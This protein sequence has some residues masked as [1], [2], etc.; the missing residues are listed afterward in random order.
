M[1]LLGIWF[2]PSGRINRR[3][4]WLRGIVLPMAINLFILGALAILTISHI[5][6]ISH[7]LFNREDIGDLDADAVE[8]MVSATALILGAAVGYLAWAI[9]HLIICAMVGIKRFHDLGKTGWY[10]AAILLAG[11]LPLMG[12]AVQIAAVIYLGCRH[13]EPEANRYGPPPGQNKTT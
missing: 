13:G 9:I 11:F 1:S 5:L 8:T 12:T 4:F 6:S 3:D 2:S 7:L 10:M